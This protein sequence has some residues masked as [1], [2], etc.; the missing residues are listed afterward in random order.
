VAAAQ[1]E[2]ETI[3][4]AV[5]AGDLKQAAILQ[6]DSAVGEPGAFEK[7]PLERQQQMLYDAKTLGPEQRRPTPLTCE[8][9]GTLNVPVLL[10]RGERTRDAARYGFEATASCLPKTAETAIIPGAPH[11]WYMRNPEDSAKAILTFIAKH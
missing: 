10:I 4:Q 3:R 9:L 2:R 11:S 6:F 8:Q 1:K 5:E 7:L